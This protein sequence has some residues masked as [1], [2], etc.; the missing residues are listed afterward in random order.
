MLPTTALDRLAFYAAQVT[1]LLCHYPAPPTI[2]S[3]ALVL[4]WDATDITEMSEQQWMMTVKGQIF[5]ASKSNPANEILTG[6]GFITPL[7]DRF[8]VNAPDRSAYHLR[9]DDGDM[10]DYCRVER[11]QPS[12]M[13]GYAG[14]SFY[15][16]EI[17][18]GI[19]LRRCQGST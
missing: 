6:D 11:V 2:N 1:G 15:G 7:V 3:P 12:L 9:T 5:I 17:Y 14:H 4:F 19:K 18:W 13:L 8:S 16:S 10:V